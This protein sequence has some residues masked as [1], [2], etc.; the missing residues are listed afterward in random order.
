VEEPLRK[1]LS[2]PVQREKEGSKYLK[3]YQIE[4]E[5]CDEVS[6]VA[7]YKEP[8]YCPICNNKIEAEEVED[9]DI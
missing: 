3:D 8:K 9:V 4:C 5:E 6:Y 7:S 2:G 1:L